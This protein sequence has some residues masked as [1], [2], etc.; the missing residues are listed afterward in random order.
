M[1]S[2]PYG[3]G[4][5]ANAL[6]TLQGSESH[7]GSSESAYNQS[8]GTSWSHT[9]GSEAS[10]ASAREAEKARQFAAKQAQINREFQE[11]LFR[12]EMEYNRVEAQKQRDYQQ[13]QVDVANKMADTIYTRS[14]ANMREAGIN[15]I[16]AFSHGLSGVGTGTVSSGQSASIGGSPSGS[17]AQSFMGQSFADQNSASSQWSKGEAS[18][19]SWQNSESGL[20]EGLQQMGELIGAG[21][22][23][24]SSAKLFEINL[25]DA[26]ESVKN[27]V[28]KQ[29]W[30]TIKSIEAGVKEGYENLKDKITNSYKKT[31]QKTKQAEK[32]LKK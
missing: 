9:A 29:G 2:I 14:A 21:L 19:S 26:T 12:E 31:Q 22:N 20:A 7:G 15:P 16:L 4:Q 32:N 30:A 5:F 11:R 24:L 1:A 17:V 27:K 25:G 3:V 13:A 23:A 6:G 18:G 8:E 10:E 28:E